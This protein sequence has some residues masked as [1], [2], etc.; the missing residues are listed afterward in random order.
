MKNRI[1]TVG[2]ILLACF[3]ISSAISAKSPHSISVGGRQH[4]D[5]SVF[6]D[7]PFS[8]GDISYSLG[9]EYHEPSGYWQIALDYTPEIDDDETVDYVLT[10][11]LNLVIT[12]KIWRGGV[13]ILKSLIESEDDSDWT[14][15]YWQILLGVSIPVGKINIEA[16]GVYAFE[17]WDELSELDSDDIEFMGRI[18]FNF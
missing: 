15:L 6:T 1:L 13:G 14:D 12:D 11:Q 10:P 17:D 4:V 18:V 7:L 16:N 2:A 5:H 3:F 8:D 9:Y